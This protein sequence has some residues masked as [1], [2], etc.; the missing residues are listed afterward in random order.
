M[1]F[2]LKLFNIGMGIKRSVVLLELLVAEVPSS[3][4][5]TDLKIVNF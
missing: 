5:Y 2:I 3:E 1:F 4:F